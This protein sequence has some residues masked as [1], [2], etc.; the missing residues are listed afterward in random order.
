MS[1]RKLTHGEVWLCRTVF[2]QSLAIN[3]IEVVKRKVIAGGFTPYGRINLDEHHYCE[4]FIGE[5]LSAPLEPLEKVHHF[6]HELCHCWQHFVG[7][8][9]LHEFRKA[10]K[11]AR[12]ERWAQGLRR[13]DLS[14]IDWRLAK[15]YSIYSYNV[16]LG[17]DLMDFSMEEQC[18]IIADY[19]AMKLWNF[20]NTRSKPPGTPYP[21]QSQLEAVL[22]KFLADPSYPRLN[23]RI[24]NARA[25]FREI[26]R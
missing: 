19:F 12:Q 23:S 25:T 22:K 1:S 21:S 20:K 13:R 5:K 3:N 15:H 4:D 17:A 24:Y 11:D 10:Q 7:M 18:E 14:K 9:M 8:A 2:K 16:S 26:E 6:L